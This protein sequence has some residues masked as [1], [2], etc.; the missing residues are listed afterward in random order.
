MPDIT[1]EQFTTIEQTISTLNERLDGLKGMAERM[2]AVE[3]QLE[4]A[5]RIIAVNKKRDISHYN[6]EE[7]WGVKSVLD[8]PEGLTAKGVHENVVVKSPGDSEIIKGFQTI[9]DDVFIL[10]RLLG[11]DVG[12]LA[13]WD[14]PHR[15]LT[16]LTPRQFTEKTGLGKALNTANGS[17]GNWV[18][19]GWG[20]EMLTD[21]RQQLLV[22]D[23]F[24]SFDMPQDPFNYPFQDAG[25]ITIYLR[26]EPT[27]DEASKITA[28]QPSD[29]NIQFSTI[30]LAARIVYSRKLEEDALTFWLPELKKG[31]TRRMAEAM[32]DAIE[33]GDVTA[34]HMDS[35]VVLGR[36][37][38]KAWKGLRKWANVESTEYDV[39]TG[40]SSF[41][42]SSGMQVQAKMTGGYGVPS[43]EGCWIIGNTPYIKA[44]AF[45]EFE[46]FDKAGARATIFSGQ[47]AMWYGWPVIVS[48][49]IREDLNSSGVYQS[50]QT[51]SEFL[52]VHHPSFRIGYRREEDIETDRDIETGQNIIV[53]TMRAHFRATRPTGQKIVAAGINV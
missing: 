19:Q 43:A 37:H 23:V 6:E 24:Q 51:K 10:A 3:K 40:D 29:D 48:P 11:K 4:D 30:E 2:E 35:D 46:T 36:D 1:V 16:G 52:G 27:E 53:A 25:G 31:I 21:Y 39:T 9:N 12:E 13:Y 15:Q 50:G 22:E 42:A 44:R 32:E 45:D 17:G 8:I 18:P 41:Q 5:Q 28:S 33:N 38:R 20:D 34:T 49:K 47:I 14:K 7:A 26:Q